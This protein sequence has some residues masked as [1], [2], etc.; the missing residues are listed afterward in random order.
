MLGRYF[1]ERINKDPAG[2]ANVDSFSLYVP[3]KSYH[4]NYETFCFTSSQ[5]FQGED[6][7]VS[8]KNKLYQSSTS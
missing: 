4:D 6:A 7:S 1:G 2:D 3:T 8:A 5:T